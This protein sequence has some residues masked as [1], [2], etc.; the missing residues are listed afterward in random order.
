MDELRPARSPGTIRVPNTFAM[1]PFPFSP[2]SDGRVS[3][4]LGMFGGRRHSVQTCLFL[5]KG[6]EE[7]WS[8]CQT[9]ESSTNL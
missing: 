2:F 6:R 9:H 5:I 1:S 7:P 4:R 8:P 3:Y